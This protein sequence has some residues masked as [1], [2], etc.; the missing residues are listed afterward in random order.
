MIESNRYS[1][2]DPSTSLRVIDILVGFHPP[3]ILV[4]ILLKN[5]AGAFIRHFR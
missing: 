5:L 2:A 3:L 4:S 1:V